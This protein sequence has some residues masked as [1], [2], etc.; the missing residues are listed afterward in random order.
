MRGY[1]QRV[2]AMITP[3]REENTPLMTKHRDLE[4][5][6]YADSDTILFIPDLSDM[7]LHIQTPHTQ[8]THTSVSPVSQYPT[9]LRPLMHTSSA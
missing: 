4:A 1:L 6:G 9:P 7:P 3:F 2:W 5:Y 8:R